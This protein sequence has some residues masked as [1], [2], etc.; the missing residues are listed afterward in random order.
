MRRSAPARYAVRRTR[1]KAARVLWVLVQTSPRTLGEICPRGQILAPSV[2]FSFGPCTARFL[3]F[4]AQKKRKWGVQWT[5]HP[6][7]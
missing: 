1:Q 6:H 7:G 3:F 4:C 2:F 5:S